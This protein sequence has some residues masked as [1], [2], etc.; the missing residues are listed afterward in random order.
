MWTTAIP[1]FIEDNCITFED[2]DENSH[3]HFK[4][5][6]EFIHL[7]NSCLESCTSEIG[8]SKEDFAKAVAVGLQIEDYK[9]YFE[10]LFLVDDFNV[11]KAKM[12]QKN[13]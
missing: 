7:V 2:A 9:P 3:E 4:I 8:I 13:I 6:K 12:V 1:T 5:H 11:F 10:S